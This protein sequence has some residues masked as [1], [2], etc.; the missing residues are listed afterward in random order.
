M[1]FFALADCLLLV[2]YNRKTRSVESTAKNQQIRLNLR[3]FSGKTYSLEQ[4]I[5]I[6]DPIFIFIVKSKSYFQVT[7]LA[8][9]HQSINTCLGLPFRNELCKGQKKWYFPLIYLLVLSLKELDRSILHF[10]M[11]QSEYTSFWGHFKDRIVF[12][13]CESLSL[14]CS[15]ML[16][17]LFYFFCVVVLKIKS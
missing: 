8:H 2:S 10:F 1:A 12:M 7:N 4:I 11:H 15:F 6:Y 5:L 14:C 13:R 3:H 17:Q 16:L 9:P